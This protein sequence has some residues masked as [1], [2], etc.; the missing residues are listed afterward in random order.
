M[1][2]RP[3][4]NYRGT[5]AMHVRPHRKLGKHRTLIKPAFS[6]LDELSSDIRISKI[7]LGR[8]MGAG[9]TPFVERI[10]C[11]VSGSQIRVL[12]A[13]P[14]CAQIVTLTVMGAKNVENVVNHLKSRW[15]PTSTELEGRS[16][17]PSQTRGSI[18]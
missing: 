17:P 16:S 2:L 6:L 10:E 1:P 9:G 18:K 15:P 3:D 14:Y 11:V 4:E 8:V 5:H 13:L 7:D 12:L